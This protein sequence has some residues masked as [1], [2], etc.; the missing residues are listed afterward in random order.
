MIES[1]NGTGTVSRRLS[2]IVS[3]ASGRQYVI[4]NPLVLGE[5]TDHQ[6]GKWYYQPYPVLPGIVPGQPFESADEAERAARSVDSRP[7]H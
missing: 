1:R 5:P 4:Y 6:A 7:V 3:C 2:Y